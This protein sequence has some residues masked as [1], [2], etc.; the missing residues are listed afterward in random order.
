M[1]VERKIIDL[2]EKK[3]GEQFQTISGN[4]PVP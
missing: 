3:D 4:I 1:D 2:E